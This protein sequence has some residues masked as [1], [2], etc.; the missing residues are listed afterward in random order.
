MSKTT[1]LLAFGAGYVLG[2][3]A[4]RDRYDQIRSGAQKVASNPT[5]QSAAGRAQEVV[6]HQAAVVADA[7]KQKAASVAHR[8]GAGAHQA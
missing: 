5:V 7:A 3:R 4:G 1:L 8:D 2:A 6:G